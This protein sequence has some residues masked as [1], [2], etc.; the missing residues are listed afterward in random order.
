MSGVRVRVGAIVLSEQRL[1]L[2][3][4]QKGERS[5][6]L[7]PGG[8]LE[9]GETMFDC[10]TREVREETGLTV[11]P[12]RLVFVSESIAPPG[13]RH[14]LNVLVKAQL[15]GGHLAPPVGDVISEVAWVPL[16]QLAELT[17][18][19]PLAPALLEAANEGFKSPLRYMHTPWI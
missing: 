1:L 9:A 17:L 11:A 13:G 7:L 10:A 8:G 16:E 15:V 12:E 4:H 18:H 3:Q 19:P 2:V 5:Y 14:I 6:W